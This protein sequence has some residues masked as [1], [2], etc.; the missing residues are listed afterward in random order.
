MSNNP[1]N[2]EQDSLIELTETQQDPGRAKATDF[3]VQQMTE[4]DGNVFTGQASPALIAES[5]KMRPNEPIP[6]RNTIPAVSW[7]KLD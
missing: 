5:Q 6:D 7:R 4:S 2:S 3:K 1:K